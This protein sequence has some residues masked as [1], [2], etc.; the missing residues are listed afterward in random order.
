MARP[1]AMDATPLSGPMYDTIRV[2]TPVLRSDHNAVDV[3]RAPSAHRESV[4][5]KTID[6]SLRRNMP[7]SCS[8]FPHWTTGV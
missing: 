3:R 6:K 5:K 8:T 2:V 1:G 7:Y 4:D